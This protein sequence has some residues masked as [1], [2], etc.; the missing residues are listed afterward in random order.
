[1]DELKTIIRMYPS[2][3]DIMNGLLGLDVTR[4]LTTFENRVLQSSNQKEK[5]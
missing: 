4:K 3:H 5:I 2:L 1:M